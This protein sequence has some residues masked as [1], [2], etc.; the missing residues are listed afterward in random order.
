MTNKELNWIILICK[1][2]N[3]HCL[4]WL[5]VGHVDQLKKERKNGSFFND[6]GWSRF[7]TRQ[8]SSMIHSARPIFT[9]VANIVFCFVF[10]DL[11]SVD[12]RTDGQL[13][14]KQWSL[15][16]VTLGWPSGSIEG[17]RHNK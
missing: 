14:R 13:V 16:A 8:V 15:P 4:P 6:D 2:N 1:E 11:K 10:L 7:Q 3:D 9:P 5:L 12:G 17:R